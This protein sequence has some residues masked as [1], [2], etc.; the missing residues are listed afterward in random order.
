MSL[1]PRSPRGAPSSTPRNLHHAVLASVDALLVSVVLIVHALIA[2]CASLS[3][4]PEPVKV[5]L[6]DLRPSNMTLLEQSY[7]LKVRVQ[8]PNDAALNVRGM[9]YEISLNGKEFAHGVRGE[10]FTVPAFG[11]TIVAGEIVSTVFS[12]YEQIREIQRNPTQ[13]FQYEINGSLSLGGGA[14]RVPF[15]YKGE[16]DFSPADAGLAL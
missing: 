15:E 2:G 16:L 10:P 12:F 7:L 9:S 6:S 3:Q 8:N 14:G 4:Y 13:R 11:E 5:T 1:G